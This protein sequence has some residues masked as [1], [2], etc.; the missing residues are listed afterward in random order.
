MQDR[1]VKPVFYAEAGIRNYWRIEID[2]FKGR[3]PGEEL[4]VLFAYARGDDGEYQLTNRAAAGTSVTLESPFE[5]TV[6]PATLMR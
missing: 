6:D 2:P 3:L 1:L 4:P 5:F